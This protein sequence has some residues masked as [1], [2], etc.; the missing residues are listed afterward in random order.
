MQQCWVFA[1]AVSRLHA[2]Q[3]VERLRAGGVSA[4]DVSV[5]VP[6][7]ASGPAGRS[8]GTVLSIAKSGPLGWL[9]SLA[10]LPSLAGLPAIAGGPLGDLLDTAGHGGLLPALES[11]QVTEGEAR[12]LIA[13]LEAG[14]VLLSVRTASPTRFALTCDLFRRAGATDLTVGHP[15]E[16]PSPASRQAA[17]ALP[18][19]A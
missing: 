11:L 2:E 16:K 7:S 19:F 14:Q 12:R 10:E 4:G 5:V 8:L 17:F 3:V 6:V 15:A 18:R 1:V 13:R 9:R